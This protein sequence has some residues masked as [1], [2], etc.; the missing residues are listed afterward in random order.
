MNWIERCIAIEMERE[1]G[2]RER[3][4]WRK[5]ECAHNQDIKIAFWRFGQKC[6]STMCLQMAANFHNWLNLKMKM[7]HKIIWTLDIYSGNSKK[8]Q[9]RCD[10]KVQHK[11]MA[12]WYDWQRLPKCFNQHLL[13]K[14]L[15]RIWKSPENNQ[16]QRS[17]AL[18]LQ[19]VSEA[20]AIYNKGMYTT[21]MYRMQIDYSCWTTSV[22]SI[23]AIL[24]R[25]SSYTIFN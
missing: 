17:S 1:R 7:L 13:L 14:W 18:S 20:N 16:Q 6:W 23:H 10:I 24:I 3:E 25:L 2:K 11:S 9:Q 22:I 12:R 4:Q 21:F 8:K 19:N 5:A 15:Y